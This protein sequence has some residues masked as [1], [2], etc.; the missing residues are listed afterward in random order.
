M[1]SSFTPKLD[2]FGG[3]QTYDRSYPLQ[4]PAYQQ[5]DDDEDDVINQI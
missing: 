2:V 5:V 3:C 1:F 4:Q